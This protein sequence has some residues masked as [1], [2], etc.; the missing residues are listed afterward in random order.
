M[1]NGT[2]RKAPSE[3]CH[4]DISHIPVGSEEII[5]TETAVCTISKGFDQE[6]WLR[7]CVSGTY[8]GDF[9]DVSGAVE[10]ALQACFPTGW[11]R[12][13]VPLS[14]GREAVAQHEL[15]P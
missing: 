11:S 5:S 7:L 15:F 13:G 9:F 10:Q 8:D 1:P 2:V 3:K 12:G 4:P 6:I 14:E